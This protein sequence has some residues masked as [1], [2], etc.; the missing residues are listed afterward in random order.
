MAA[1]N[2]TMGSYT[3]YYIHNLHFIVYA[4]SMQGRRAEAIQAADEMAAAAAPMTAMM[5]EMAD[6]FLTQ[7]VFAR[8]RPLDWDGVLK[9]PRPDG[10]LSAMTAMWRYA[11]TLAELAKGER[12]AALKERAALAEAS[13]RVPAEAG[14]GQNKASDVMKLAGEIVAARFGEDAVS[15]WEKAVAI[16]D[17]LV[18]DEPPAWYYPVRESLG[19][20]LV[21]A[22]KAAEGEAVLREG[23]RRSPRNG[24]MLFGLVEALKAQGKDFAEV[25]REFDAVW[26]KSDVR[27]NL[28]AL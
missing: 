10:K 23:L 19:A 3:P 15:H 5:P 9:M 2:V 8:V 25:Q 14:W 17:G 11:R 20:E 21:R 4:R 26:A 24:F 16:Q 12:A 1:S 28:G 7:T 27:L 13:G 18:Y 22:G 6:A